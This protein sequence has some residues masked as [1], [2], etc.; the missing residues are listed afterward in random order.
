MSWYSDLT[1]D[2]MIEYYEFGRIT[3]DELIEFF[4]DLKTVPFSFYEELE[5]KCDDFERRNY[6]LEEDIEDLDDEIKLLTKEL[7]EF[8]INIYIPKIKGERK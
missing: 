1:K 2:Q 4:I 5:I 8:N 6:S 7:R 3:K